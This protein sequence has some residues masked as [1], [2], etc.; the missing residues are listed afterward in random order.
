MKNEDIIPFATA[1]TEPSGPI[2]ASTRNK[3]SLHGTATASITDIE[4]LTEESMEISPSVK[5]Q[6]NDVE[7]MNYDEGALN[8]GG[9]ALG[10]ETKWVRLTPDD[11]CAFMDPPTTQAMWLVMEQ[12]SYND[13]VWYRP[14]VQMTDVLETQYKAKH[15]LQTVDVS[16][17]KENGSRV[18]HTYEHDLRGEEWTQKRIEFKEDGSKVVW[19]SKKIIRVV[20]K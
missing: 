12:S 4:E 1:Y 9:N 2:I 17:T 19:T 11:E 6:K 16:Y 20:L 18:T 14:A 5:R 15:G 3:R 13:N 7:I 8:R 10:G